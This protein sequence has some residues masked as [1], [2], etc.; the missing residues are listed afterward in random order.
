MENEDFVG[1]ISEKV[2][3]VKIVTFALLHLV[4]HVKEVIKKL[5]IVISVV[6]INS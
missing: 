4:E 5:I 6:I 1:S 2:K 3:G